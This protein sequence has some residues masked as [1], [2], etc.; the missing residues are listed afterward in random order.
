KLT[1][2]ETKARYYFVGS[3]S[4]E[5]SFHIL[6]IDRSLDSDGRLSISDDG[7]VYSRVEML[8]VLFRIESGNLH[9]GGLRRITSCFGIVGFV[10]FLEGYYVILITKRSPVALIGAH[11]I[12]H[13]DDTLILGITDVATELPSA[14]EAKYIQSFCQ[15]DLSKNFYFSYTYDI[16]NSLQRNLT[17][18]API[19]DSVNPHLHQNT[20]KEYNSMFIWNNF[21]LSNGFDRIDASNKWC[22]PIIYGF[23]DQAKIPV[24]GHDIYLT[25]IAR[26]SRYF[27]GARFLKRGVNDEGRVANEVETEQ[28]VHDANKTLFEY[29]HGKY[30]DNPGYTSFL[31]HRGSIPLYWSQDTSQLTPKPPIELNYV[32]PFFS[33]T[34]LHFS[35]MFSRYGTPLIILNLIKAKEKTPREGIL[36]PEFRN[37]VAYLNAHLPQDTAS[38]IQY[39]EWDMARA[40]KSDDPNEVVSILERIAADSLDV[41]GFFHAGREPYLNAVRRAEAAANIATA[42][43]GNSGSGAKIGPTGRILGRLQTGIVRTNCIDCLD[44]TNAAQFMLGKYALGLQLHALGV[45]HI[46]RVEFDSDAANLLNGMYQD[47]G[48]TIALQYGGSHLVNTMETYRKIAHWTSHSRDMIESIRRYYSNSFTDA[49]KQDAIN[50]FLGNFTPSPNGPMIWDLPTD[51]YLH[52]SPDPLV[53]A[54][55]RSYTRWWMNKDDNRSQPKQQHDEHQQQDEQKLLQTQPINQLQEEQREQQNEQQLQKLLDI[56]ESSIQTPFATPVISMSSI[57]TQSMTADE[58]F[59]DYYRPGELTSFDRLYASNMNGSRVD[60]GGV[61]G[62]ASSTNATNST[63]AN[64]AAV[65]ISGIEKGKSGVG[66]GSISKSSGAGETKS[67]GA[68][69][70][71]GRTGG[72]GGRGIISGFGVGGGTIDLSP[73]AVRVAAGDDKLQQLQ[74]EQIERAQKGG[75]HQFGTFGGLVIYQASEDEIAQWLRGSD[76]EV[77]QRKKESKSKAGANVSLT[78]AVQQAQAALPWWTTSAL[79]T[80]LMN[81]E[82]S[83]PE[84]REYKR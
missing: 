75:P 60:A 56:S 74:Q 18:G 84:S 7:I 62:S 46:P 38:Q 82:V 65:N 76:I 34:A 5:D 6:K 12:Y 11:Y 20:T 81:P 10:K 4:E 16:T 26:R 54:V 52:H 21:L 43:S 39:I 79:S 36:L 3:S 67:S 35:D 41:T 51:Y 31:Q 42:G 71:G 28:I 13:I 15:V 30:G 83:K 77:I 45:L 53:K 50:L 17:A 55:R 59:T 37:A 72:G 49:E 70:T 32:D 63:S 14:E 2:Y 61:A 48:D 44:R 68:T 27:A 19:P 22:L 25:I 58:A 47:H 80:R 33:A 1:L 24:F 78:P 29:P 40:N 66:D 8:N 23:V 69:G 57:L 73:F 9:I 64:N